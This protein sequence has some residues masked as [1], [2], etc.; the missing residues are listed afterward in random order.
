MNYSVELW[1]NYNKV[2]KTLHFHLQGLKE[3]IKLYTE[4]YNNQLNYASLLK[5]TNKSNKQI[6]VFESLYHGFSLFKDEMLN[7]YK[8]LSEFLNGIKNEIIKPLTSLYDTSLKR[9]NYNVYEMNSIE[10]SYQA[11][12]QSLENAKKYFHTFAKDAEQS[13]IKSESYKEKNDNHLNSLIKKE[14]TNMLNSLKNAKEYEKKYIE[15]IDQTNNLQGEYIEIKKRNLM[16]VQDIE[17]EVAEN[18]KDS[19]RKFITFQIA[20]I[21]NMEYDIKKKSSIFEGIKLNKDINKFI[22]NNKTGITMLYKYKYIPYI[23]QFEKINENDKK[24]YSENVINNVKL[25]MSNIFSKER[26][27]EIN[28]SSEY[29]KNEII[30]EE[31]KGIIIKIFDKEIISNKIK[32]NINK[33]I[34]LKKTRRQLL[35]E[36]NS[37]DLSNLNES[38]FDNISYLL[39]EV[40]KVLQIEKDYESVNLL[41]N[42]ITN[43]CQNSENKEKRKLFIQNSLI[44]QK[45]FA[46]YE[47]WKELIKYNIVEE[48]FNQKS[49]N[50]SSSKKENEEKNSLNI[51]EIVLSKINIYLNYMIDFK[52]KCNFMKQIIEEFKDYYELNDDDIEKFTSK[53]NEY[54]KIVEKKNKNEIKKDENENEDNTKNLNINENINNKEENN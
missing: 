33:L 39:K 41:L 49:S 36:I 12:I 52:C 2:Q 14:E 22:N 13:K 25:F 44:D 29:N 10:Q 23:S 24:I 26:P 19:F 20:Y 37:K 54:N 38:S 53:I 4:Q 43:F 47:F 30:S 11:S 17:Q 3:I 5:N 42:F 8:Y 1:D 16:E 15:L 32:E 46:S 18:I 50:L 7:Q 9:L 31:I 21:R 35:K 51:K 28:P 34:L 40:L 48:M 6:T 27:N 45:I